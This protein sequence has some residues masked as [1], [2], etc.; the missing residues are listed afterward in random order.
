MELSDDDSHMNTCS[1]EPIRVAITAHFTLH[2][3]LLTNMLAAKPTPV[4]TS[5]TAPHST[6]VWS[7]VRLDRMDVEL[8]KDSK[9]YT[10]RV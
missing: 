4:Y 1:S 8:I 10:S 6:G 7:N 5:V 9:T 3:F 2:P